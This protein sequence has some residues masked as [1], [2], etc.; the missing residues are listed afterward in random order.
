M[1]LPNVARIKGNRKIFDVASN[2]AVNPPSNTSDTRQYELASQLFRSLD[3]KEVVDIF[4][5]MM[6]KDMPHDSIEYSNEQFGISLTVGK[7]Q[8]HRLEYTLEL[9]GQ[10]LGLLV[11]T[12]GRVFSDREISGV[13]ELMCSLVYPLR[14]AILY[15]AAL[16]S[17]YRDPLTG[18]DNRAS[19]D[20]QL[21]REI[22]LAQRHK[23]AL[24]VLV[25]DI[26]HF[27]RINDNHGHQVGDRVLCELADVMK[28]CIRGTDQIFRYGGDEFVISLASTPLDGAIDVAE[29][30]RHRIERACFEVGNIRL[31]VSTSIGVAEIHERD[32]VDS[33]FRRADN[34]MLGSKRDGRNRVISA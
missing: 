20:R 25:V 17:A 22:S 34:A 4:F 12:R 26:D 15:K 33:I 23:R 2:E 19:L 8:R 18:V 30:I 3:V 14:N 21:P 9:A 1:N 5:T 28:E 10:S 6:Q 31:V 7:S 11:M 13:E 32:T 29:R 27:K 16:E 24:S